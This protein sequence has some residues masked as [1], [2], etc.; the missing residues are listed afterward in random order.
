MVDPLTLKGIAEVT[1]MIGG[2]TVKPPMRELS[3]AVTTVFGIAN[4]LLEPIEVARLRYEQRM[5]DVRRRLLDKHADT[6][7]ERLQEI[8]ASIAGPTVEALRYIGDDEEL[9]EMFATLLATAAD[10]ATAPNAHPAFADIIRQLTADEARVLGVLAAEP[11]RSWPVIHL[12][13]RRK[14]DPADKYWVVCRS[15]SFLDDLACVT[16]SQSMPTYLD[17]ICRL[18]L[19]EM[20]STSHVDPVS[21]Y[22]ALVNHPAIQG[23]LQQVN[24]AGDGQ[25]ES[26]VQYTLIRLTD[27]GRQFLTV[28]ISRPTSTNSTPK[29]TVAG[30]TDEPPGPPMLT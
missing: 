3:K 7:P 24:T 29:E 21:T 6:P 15:Q 10:R 28:C 8:A 12:V 2:D 25:Q 27:F 1:S 26:G 14:G 23:V 17:N 9:R 22:D 18:G 5:A 16:Y 4:L 20:P 11:H 13:G 30:P 19:A